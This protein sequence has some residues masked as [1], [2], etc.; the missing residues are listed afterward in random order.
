MASLLS[1]Q[2]TGMSTNAHAQTQILECKDAQGRKILA[3][4]CPAGSTQVKEVEVTPVT[5]GLGQ[6]PKA[7][8]PTQSLWAKEI[9]F[10]ERQKFKAEQEE[11]ART[12]ER[13]DDEKCYQN[14]KKLVSLENGLPY[15][16]G[17]TKTGDPIFMEDQDRVKEIKKIKEKL[18][19]CKS[20]D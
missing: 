11:R 17:E 4:R 1:I 2:L 12:L 7:K 19:K 18:S 8:V 6:Q 3:S 14:K 5:N 13:A 9:E 15:K 10:K 16:T 20:T